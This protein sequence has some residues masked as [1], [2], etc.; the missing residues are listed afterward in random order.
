[1]GSIALVAAVPGKATWISWGGL[2]TKIYILKII[3]QGTK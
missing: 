2:S 1:M 3:F